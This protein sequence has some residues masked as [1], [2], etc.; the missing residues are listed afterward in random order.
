[1]FF[2]DD[3][4]LKP[5]ARRSGKLFDPGKYVVPARASTE[6]Q[7]DRPCLTNVRKGVKQDETAMRGNHRDE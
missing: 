4:S 5:Q 7:P 6:S 2:S 3:S 1:M